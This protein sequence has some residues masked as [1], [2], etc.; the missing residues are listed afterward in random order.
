MDG[1]YDVTYKDASVGKAE[2]IRTGLY[3]N[4][5]CRCELPDGK[6]YRLV[7]VWDEG[8]LSIGIPVPD[9]KGFVLKKRL[10]VKHLGGKGLQFLLLEASINPGEVICSVQQPEAETG[11][12]PV[13]EAVNVPDIQPLDYPEDEEKFAVISEDEPF[14]QL[15]EIMDARLEIREEGPVAVFRQDSK[16]DAETDGA[17]IGAQNIGVYG[18]GDDVIPDSV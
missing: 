16:I 10:P 8:Y 12:N 9:T 13:E 11:K 18:C 14:P 1:F 7:A 4:V 5:T 2:L 15:H 3:W 6:M 17:V